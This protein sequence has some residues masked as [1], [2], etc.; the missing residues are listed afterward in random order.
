MLKDGE[1]GA[2]ECPVVVR[3]R[4]ARRNLRAQITLL[5]IA[6]GEVS[7]QRTVAELTALAHLMA[8]S[9]TG[10]VFESLHSPEPTETLTRPFVH[11]M[12]EL[13]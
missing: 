8:L 3:W 2:S 10:L 6:M 11:T 13:V 7:T 9:I 12:Q 1:I 4:V 5:L